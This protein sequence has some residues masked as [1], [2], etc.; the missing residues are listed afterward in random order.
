[1]L[2]RFLAATDSARFDGDEWRAKFKTIAPS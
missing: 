1:V 2:E